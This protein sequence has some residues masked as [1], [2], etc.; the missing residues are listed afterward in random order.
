MWRDI[1]GGFVVSPESSW[2]TDRNSVQQ[3]VMRKINPL[4]ESLR[5]HE[6]FLLSQK[7]SHGMST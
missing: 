1:Q 6:S 4:E 7:E 2:L 5:Y 3:N